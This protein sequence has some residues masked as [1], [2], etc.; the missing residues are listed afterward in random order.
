MGLIKLFPARK[1]LVSDIP[2]EDRKT[3]YSVLMPDCFI[4]FQYV[5]DDTRTA[6]MN[7]VTV[8]LNQLKPLQYALLFLVTISINSETLT[9]EAATLKEIF[10]D[11]SRL[12]HQ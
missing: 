8:T 5:K 6:K 4:N 10:E 9:Y 2:A 11:N 1:S 7:T 12:H 3:A